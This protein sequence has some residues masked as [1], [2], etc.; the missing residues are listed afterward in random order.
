VCH[1]CETGL[2]SGCVSYSP[3]PIE[4]PVAGN[5]LTCCSIPS[6]DLDLDL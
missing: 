5:V 1:T 2:I 6:H 3:E 4:P